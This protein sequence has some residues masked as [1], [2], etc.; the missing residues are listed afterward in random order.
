[1]TTTQTNAATLS[2]RI[3]IELLALD[4]SACSRCVGTAKNLQTAISLV[5][6]LLREVGTEVAYHDT[7][8]T[9]VEQAANLRLRSSPTV[10]I[11]GRDMIT[12]LRENSCEDCGELCGCGDGVNCQVWA[13][14]G[15]EHLEAPV[16]L[17]IDALLKEY[18]KADLPTAEA[19]PPFSLPENLQRF[20]TSRQA[21][22]TG[23]TKCCDD[24]ACCEPVDKAACCGQDAAAK[25]CGC[26]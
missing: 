1:M 22:A 4:L 7:V 12:E 15:V 20:F 17:L 6:D 25:T 10:R 2:K 11:N 21:Q 9:S 5:K 23:E 16:A 14:Q 3:D 26:K 8:V 24:Q 19:P 13:W 18:A